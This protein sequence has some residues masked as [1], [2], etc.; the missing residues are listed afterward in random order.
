MTF[1]EQLE[2]IRKSS[3]FHSKWY[4]QTHPDVGNTPPEEHYLRTGAQQGLNPG[5]FFDTKFYTSYYPDAGASD[6]NPLVH[7]ELVGLA[8]NRALNTRRLRPSH[9]E[10]YAAG[11]TA[12]TVAADEAAKAAAK[13]AKAAAKEAAKEAAKTAKATAKPAAKT[14][15]KPAAKT[16]TKPAAKTATKAA[17]KPAAKTTAKPAAKAAAKTPPSSG[18]ALETL[19]ARARA[20]AKKGDWVAATRYWQDVLAL[21]AEPYFGLAQAAAAMGDSGRAERIVLD[22]LERFEGN[23]MLLRQHCDLALKARRWLDVP[24]RWQRI[25]DSGIQV[26]DAFKVQVAEAFVAL[27]DLDH[28]TTL[29]EEVRTAMTGDIRLMKLDATLAEKRED[30]A[31]AAEIWL[32]RGRV[33]KGIAKLNSYDKGVRALMAS[34]NLNRAEA[35]IQSLVAR[36]PKEIVYLKLLA[37]VAVMQDAWDVALERWQRVEAAD[38]SQI[39]GIPADWVYQMGLETARARTAAIRMDSLRATGMMSLARIV[40]SVDETAALIMARQARR[41]YR[42][43]VMEMVA[44]VMSV[45]TRHSSAIWWF[46]RLIATSRTPRKYYPNLIESLLAASRSEECRAVVEEY[47]QRFG[48]D[49]LWLRAMAEIHYRDGDFAAMRDVMEAGMATKLA[50]E[51]RSVRV[52]RWLY[53]LVRLH[54]DPQGFLPAEI[55][56]LVL[57]VAARYEIR[58]VSDSLA[59]LLDPRKGDALA[60]TYAGQLAEAQAGT[61]ELDPVL[62]EQILQ[63]FLRRRDWDRVQAVLDL[64]LDDLLTAANVTKVWNIVRNKMD[65]LLGRAD[66]AGAEA[67]ACDFLDRLAEQDL[68]SFT[69]RQ[70]TAM[71]GRLPVSVPVAERLEAAAQWAGFKALADRISD[72]RTRYGGFPTDDLLGS[73]RRKRCFIVGNAPSIATLPLHLLEGEDIISVNRGMRALSVGLPQ[74]KY[75]V[76][77]DAMLYKNHAEEIDADGGS[78]DKFFVASNC[79]WRATPGVPCIPLGSSGLKLSLAPFEHAPLHLHRGETV[80]VMAAQLAHLMGYTEIYI[81]GVD[82]DYSGPATHFYVSESGGKKEAERLANFRPGGSGTEMVNLAFANLQ[83]VVARDGCSLY[84][85]A[86]AGKL[87]SLQRVRFADLFGSDVAHAASGVQ[88][89]VQSQTEEASS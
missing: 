77:A 22:G 50:G 25:V 55:Q 79:L 65:I 35:E 61:R 37:Q 51:A 88:T 66:V 40:E 6:L 2:I 19:S 32:Q 67:V 9:R 13:E 80:V 7:Y 17:A 73:A 47:V 81:I 63:F 64:P 74:P 34:G 71:L 26:D 28:A 75:L 31:G 59:V 10:A 85:A 54:P 45:N 21:P 56:D 53:E 41:F 70:T 87:D 18:S 89:E 76:V 14:V 86:P 58:F 12:V 3:Q 16:A 38:P 5:K 33:A 20:A 4:A 46:R 78:V 83:T 43:P 44:R 68:R 49:M 29:L 8:E 52:L 69:L 48:R 27:G 39:G 62:R 72:W 23:S 84:N 1:E 30:W 15:A 11:G 60:E 42:E 57:R 36:F 82:L 24:E